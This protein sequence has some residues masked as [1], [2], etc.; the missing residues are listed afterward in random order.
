MYS[1]NLMEYDYI[2]T[3]NYTETGNPDLQFYKT[4]EFSAK[5]DETAIEKAWAKA[6]VMEMLEN[7]KAGSLPSDPRK[8]IVLVGVRN[9]YNKRTVF[10][11]GYFEN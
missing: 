7:N 6:L 9:Q 10:S 4:E 1:A 11:A 5:D 3:F 8:T 2:A